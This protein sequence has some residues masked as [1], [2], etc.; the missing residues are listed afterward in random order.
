MDRNVYSLYKTLA[1]PVLFENFRS[2]CERLYYSDDIRRECREHLRCEELTTVQR[3]FYFFAF[4]RLSVN[5][6]G[7]F[8][9]NTAQR[10]GMSKSVSDFLSCIDRLPELHRRL[11][12]VIVTHEDG[13]ELIKRYS[14]SD[15][16]IYCDP[17]YEHSTRGSTRYACDMNTEDHIRFLEACKHSRSKIL[18]SGYDCPLYDT[19]LDYGFRKEQFEVR[20]TSAH[21]RSK[22]KIET[23]WR[24][25]P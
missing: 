5:G 20:T 13:I 24:N 10:R 7:G 6:I 22:T 23:L 16:L 3:A 11:Q 18:V 21:R 25:Y 9:K 8:S 17:P 19:L 1:D 12:R 15:A 2:R 4:N 14:R